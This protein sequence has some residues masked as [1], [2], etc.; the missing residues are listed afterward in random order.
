[1]WWVFGGEG[2]ASHGPAEDNFARG[3]AYGDGAH[4]PGRPLRGVHGR[5]PYPDHVRRQRFAVDAAV[6]TRTKSWKLPRTS[7][8]SSPTPTPWGDRSSFSR[9]MVGSSP[10]AASWS[11][12]TM[13][14]S[15]VSARSRASRNRARLSSAIWRAM[16]GGHAAC[17]EIR[18]LFPNVDLARI[19]H[20]GADG[21]LLWLRA[22]VWA[23]DCFKRSTTKAHT[24][25]GSPYEV[26]SGTYRICRWC[27]SSRKASC[28]WIA[29]KNSTSSR[30]RATFST[31]GTTTRSPV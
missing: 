29:R 10:S 12:G 2:C 16:K 13:L 18:R 25:W 17:H 22:V 8:S 1:M 4:R 9:A 15:D 27:R 5:V 23:A 24:G 26:F 19:S 28:G 21:S 30:H 7:R 20:V 11:S 6:R 31:T 3:E 14:G